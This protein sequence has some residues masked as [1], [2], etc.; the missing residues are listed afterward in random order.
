MLFCL[1]GIVS[2]KGPSENGII[3]L[4]RTEFIPFSSGESGL[5]R[6]NGMNSVLRGIIPHHAAS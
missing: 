4:R 6:M 5:R 3:A 2:G 1:A